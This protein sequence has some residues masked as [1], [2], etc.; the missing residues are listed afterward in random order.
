MRKNLF[1][2]NIFKKEFWNYFFCRYKKN[3][4]AKKALVGDATCNIAGF[5]S[6]YTGDGAKTVLPGEALVKIDF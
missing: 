6:G 3:L 2:Q 1:D 5:V 4:D